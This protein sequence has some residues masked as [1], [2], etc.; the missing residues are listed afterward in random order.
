MLPFQRIPL[1]HVGAYGVNWTDGQAVLGPLS[2]V[3]R[4]GL[5]E[6]WEQSLSY[7][8]SPAPTFWRGDVY[9]PFPCRSGPRGL[10]G[11]ASAE[12]PWAEKS[13]QGVSALLLPWATWQQALPHFCHSP[14][15]KEGK[16]KNRLGLGCIDL[17]VF[18]WL[19]DF[20]SFSVAKRKRFIQFSFSVKAQ[21][22]ELW[23]GRKTREMLPIRQ[24]Y[25]RK[26]IWIHNLWIIWGPPE[27]LDVASPLWA[28]IHPVPYSSYKVVL[29]ERREIFTLVTHLTPW[30]A[31]L[32]PWKTTADFCFWARPLLVGK[33]MLGIFSS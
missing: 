31:C 2:P 7:C 30:T 14:W 6:R 15:G 23:L 16:R 22:D 12:A 32:L 33:W 26:I 1:P 27:H 3:L 10:R 17:P 13:F 20:T 11:R 29:R 18:S 19:R 4:A 5:K 25:H 28:L 8:L 24:V 9:T 21:E